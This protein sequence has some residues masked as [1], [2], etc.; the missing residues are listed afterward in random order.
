V[1]E[2]FNFY[3]IYGYLIPGLVLLG[4]LCVPFGV[5][6]RIWPKADI[7]SAVLILL[8]AYV[9]G[10]VI[11]SFALSLMPSKIPDREGNLR[12]PSDLVLD[13][14]DSS[15]T[16][17]T[18]QRI[19]GLAKRYFQLDVTPAENI[20]SALRKLLEERAH[21]DRTF[22]ENQAAIAAELERLQR[23]TPFLDKSQRELRKKRIQEQQELVEASGKRLKDTEH[24]TRAVIQ[25]R[26]EAFFLARSAL[27]RNEGHSYWEQFEGLY[28]MM[29]GI[30]AACSASSPYLAG[31]FLALLCKTGD[32]Q[33]MYF[34]NGVVIALLVLFLVLVLRFSI[35]SP[36]VTRIYQQVK[37]EKEPLSEQREREE[38]RLSASR[39]CLLSVPLLLG[40]FFGLNAAEFM[41]AQ[42]RDSVAGVHAPLLVLLAAFAALIVAVRC[43]GAYK[44]FAREFALAVWRDFSNIEAD[45][46]RAEGNW[47]PVAQEFSASGQQDC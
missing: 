46:T 2:K 45:W 14:S 42:I 28:A 6:F 39:V 12:H 36:P 10:H 13:H 22:S 7:T 11:Q 30:S 40:V 38:I 35:S 37:V 29:R 5:M 34:W 41:G 9:L 21:F 27:L 25:N 44:T 3:D 47:S 1:I 4:I 31:W 32:R 8:L 24:R 17:V 18:K 33:Q 43:F 20:G 15:F 26:D 23:D 16:D 19:A